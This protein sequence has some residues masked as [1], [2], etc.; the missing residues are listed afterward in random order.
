MLEDH[1][2]QAARARLGDHKIRIFTRSAEVNQLSVRVVWE[3]ESKCRGTPGTLLGGPRN[4]P[5]AESLN[6]VG[7]L[8]PLRERRLGSVLGHLRRLYCHCLTTAMTILAI[9]TTYISLELRTRPTLRKR[10]QLLAWDHR[11]GR[12]GQP[13]SEPR[14]PTTIVWVVLGLP[15]CCHQ[16]HSPTLTR[17][18]VHPRW[19]TARAGTFELWVGHGA[20]W[21]GATVGAWVFNHWTWWRGKSVGAARGGDRAGPSDPAGGGCWTCVGTLVG[22]RLWRAQASPGGPWRERR[23]ASEA[24]TID[25]ACVYVSE[26]GCVT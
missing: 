5:L 6:D 18:P 15:L 20:G 9:D 11:G 26:C 22:W 19:F 7:M 1:R 8:R 14:G 25:G 21:C 2:P 23:V 12:A 4:C 17:S 16:L 13:R 24:A 3:G 10:E